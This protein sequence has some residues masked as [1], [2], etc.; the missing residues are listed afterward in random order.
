MRKPIAAVIVAL[1]VV[2]VAG[3]AIAYATNDSEGGETGPEADRA[4]VAA[5][6]ATGGGTATAVE[7]DGEHGGTWEVEVRRSDGS[8]VDVRLDEHYRLVVIDGDTESAD[9]DDASN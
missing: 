5:L 9:T 6:Q 1:A 2:G 4:R 8:V 3:G 7:R